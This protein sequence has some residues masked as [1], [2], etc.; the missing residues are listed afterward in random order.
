MKAK[1]VNNRKPRRPKPAVNSLG[2]ED[3]LGLRLLT[4]RIRST[5]KDPRP[6]RFRVIGVSG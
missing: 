6:Q 3:L 1:A 4:F 5:S 2:L